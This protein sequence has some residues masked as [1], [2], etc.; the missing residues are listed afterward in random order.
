MVAHGL[1]T[2]GLFLLSGSILTRGGT[3]EHRGVRGA[4]GTH[5]RTRPSGTAVLA[6]ASLGLP[7]LA[8]FVAEFHEFFA[9]TLAVYPLLAVI[10]LLGIVVTAGLFLRMLGRLFLGPLPE[11]WREFPDLGRAEVL[12]IGTLVALV[13]PRRGGARARAST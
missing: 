5:P 12:T 10:A 6:F 11:R 7:G 4:P 3:Y 8:G 9:G 13:D 2:G 1:I